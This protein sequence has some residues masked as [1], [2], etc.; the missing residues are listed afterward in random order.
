[1]QDFN[2][3]VV[4]S[5]MLTIQADMAFPFEFPIFNREEWQES[6][7]VFDFGCGNAHYIKKLAKVF[8]EK[9]FWGY[10]SDAQML[11]IARESN[12]SYP[13][14]TLLGSEDLNTIDDIKFDYFIFRLV[15]LHLKDRNIA[16][17]MINKHSKLSSTVCI[18]D[19]DDE[20][21]YTNPEPTAFTQVLL[22]LRKTANDRNLFLKIDDE[23]KVSNF[24]CIESRRIII[25]N[26]FSHARE[27]MLKYM[28][29][30]AELGLKEKISSEVATNLIEWSI[31]NNGYI[32]YGIFYKIFRKAK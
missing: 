31:R 17:N 26:S 14:L 12:S 23:L 20:G 1:M 21:F 9:H 27:S 30:T 15:L 11:S 24:E 22:N 2:L 10:E 6:K 16:Y 5:K 7:S 32:Q 13:N 25:N 3:T 29:W 19:A 28:F 8:P 4:Y 18:I